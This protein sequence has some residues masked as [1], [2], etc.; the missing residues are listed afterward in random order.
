MHIVK[1]IFQYK[2]PK[3]RQGDLYVKPFN[4]KNPLNMP[5]ACPVCNQKMEPEPGFYFGAMFISYLI[6]AFLFLGVAGVLIIFYKFSVNGAMGVVILIGVLT[7]L[8]VLRI[9]RS[10][11]IHFIVKYDSSYA[12]D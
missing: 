3:C 2:C 5:N 8:F 7:Y 11:W 4:L 9:S 10:I 6:T 1:S 12:S